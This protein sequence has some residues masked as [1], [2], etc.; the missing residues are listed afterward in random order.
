MADHLN[1]SALEAL[2]VSL[3]L[4]LNFKRTPTQRIQVYHSRL[5][6]TALQSLSRLPQLR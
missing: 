2:R 6:C 5:E 1:L 3:F 4:P